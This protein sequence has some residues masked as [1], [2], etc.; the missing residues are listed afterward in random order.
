[1]DDSP[2]LILKAFLIDN[3]FGVDPEIDT[4]SDFPIYDGHLPDAAG[5][6]DKAI[7]IYDPA[8]TSD[9]RIQRTGETVIHPG[10]QVRVR[11]NKYRDGYK[12]SSEIST[13]LDG[14]KRDTAIVGVNQYLILGVHRSPI[15]PLGP[16]ED[17]RRRH[18]FTIN[19]T[20]T[21]E[22]V[23]EINL[24]VTDTGAFVV[25]DA[26]NMVLVR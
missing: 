15:I 19:A 11:D 9:G 23:G 1:M 3:G 6:K 20:T 22:F 25:T 18:A 2:A 13:A 5:I 14:I 10:L 8:G 26:G 17:K 4:A 16:E 7:A 24:W 12:K 21:I